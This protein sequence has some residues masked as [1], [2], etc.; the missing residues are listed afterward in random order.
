MGMS[1]TG[2]TVN[3]LLPGGA[4]HTGMIPDEVPPA[5]R[6][7][8]LMPEIMVPPLLWL[9]SPDSDGMTGRRLVAT[10]WRTDLGGREA[11]EA[12]TDQAGW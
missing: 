5:L 7:K 3:A 10:R 2:V 1:G 9:V 12:A 11:A 6:Q 8:L 4:S